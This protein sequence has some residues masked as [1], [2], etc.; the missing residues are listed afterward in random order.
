MRSEFGRGLLAGAIGAV[1]LTAVHQLGRATLDHPPRMDVLG[2]RALRRTARPMG[3]RLG[4]RQAQRWT[5]AGDLVSNALY[6]ALATRGSPDGAPWRGTLLGALAGLGGVFLPGPLGLGRSPS[7]ARASTSALTVGWY[8]LGGL[9]AGIAARRMGRERG[10]PDL[11]A[12]LAT[13]VFA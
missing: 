3:V 8:T 7:R 13:N 12:R 5:L 6:Y 9:A 2:R 10:D 4:R 1:V 11:H